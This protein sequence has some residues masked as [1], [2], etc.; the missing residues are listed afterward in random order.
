MVCGAHH[1]EHCRPLF[2]ECQ[3]LTVYNV[4]LYQSLVAIRDNEANYVLNSDVH[5]YDTRG[6]VNLHVTRCRLDKVLKCFPV[7]GVRLYNRLP[8]K[9]RRLPARKFANT[10]KAWLLDNPF[11]SIAEYNAADH[12][13]I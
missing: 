12:S 9:V 2:K 1:L 3:I 11:Y 13:Q 6:N 4:Y 5:G 10:I 7:A 8:L